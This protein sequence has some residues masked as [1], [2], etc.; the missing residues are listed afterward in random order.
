MLIADRNLQPRLA[1]RLEALRARPIEATEKGFGFQGGCSA[2]TIA[3]AGP[4]LHEAGLTYP[5]LT[6]R[7]S[8]LRA[9]ARAMA[10]Y[11]DQHGVAHAPHGKTH[12]SPELAA[13]QLA[14]GAWGIT[15]ASIGQLRTYRGFG[16]DRLLLANELTDQTGIAWLASEMA[17]DPDFE[18]YCY[19]DDPR[20][21]DLLRKT[22][23]GSS[24]QRPLPVLVE[25]GH[26]DG[27][28][29]CRADSEAREVA[30][31]IA[32]SG[33]LRLA[34]V[35][36]YE[37]SIGHDDSPET[38]AHV[39]GFSRRLRALAD[40]LRPMA[41]ASGDFILSAG[42]S[43]F[44]DLVTDALTAGDTAGLRIVLRSG[45][46][47][48]HD[49]GMYAMSSPETRGVPDAPRFTPAI[50]VWAQVLSRPEP[51]LAVIG[52]GRRDAGFDAG[53]PVP[54]R[55][56]DGKEAGPDWQVTKL[57][58]QHAYLSL[59][60]SATLSPGDLV[61]FGISHPCTTLDKWRVMPIVDDHGRV[62]DV[63]HA[64]F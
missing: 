51:D 61:C 53:L 62:I 57:M 41:D 23:G 49:H 64:F 26:A 30:A 22:Y 10:A 63:V 54:L 8:A 35:A 15:V 21:V 36:G 44:F 13:L 28:T 43:S 34:G 46:Y 19:A 58:D 20:T 37:G 5:L 24:P 47:L 59:P 11:F 48:T 12:M 3:A 1:E 39:A 40:V 38:L 55:T 7:E 56:A 9:N 32:A 14:H 27:R 50:E 6:L 2:A 52:L 16:F 31:A 42:G 29:G 4:P 25:I 60:R 33:S 18:P 17:A 45:A